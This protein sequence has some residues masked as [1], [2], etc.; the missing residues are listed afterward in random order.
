VILYADSAK[1]PQQPCPTLS[2]A[3]PL[4][5]SLSRPAPQLRYSPP[6]RWR[7]HCQRHPRNPLLREKRHDSAPPG[8]TLEVRAG[9]GPKGPQVTEILSVDSS[10]AQQ[11]MH[12][13]HAPAPGSLGAGLQQVDRERM[14]QRMRGD[15]ACHPGSLTCLPTGALDRGR[16]DRYVMLSPRLLGILR[17]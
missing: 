6:R 14:A 15:R 9:P 10:T 3:T 11:E 16:K 1:E 17:D 13:R 12:L 4:L 8:A 5:R 2:G 7:H